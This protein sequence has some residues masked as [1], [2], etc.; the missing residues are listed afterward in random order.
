M[1]LSDFLPLIDSWLLGLILALAA[2]SFLVPNQMN[3]LIKL[4]VGI[5]MASI[6]FVYLA[7]FVMPFAGGDRAIAVRILLFFLGLTILIFNIGH[8]IIDYVINKKRA[9]LGLPTTKA[10]VNGT[11]S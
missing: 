7:D 10:G 4:A 9:K 6:G 8:V 1:T 11:Q 5:N 2:F 3:W